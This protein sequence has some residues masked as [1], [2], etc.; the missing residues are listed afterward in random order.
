MTNIYSDIMMLKTIA[1]AATFAHLSTA[2]Q[3][4]QF[5][6]DDNC[7]VNCGI[8]VNLANPG[9]L[10]E[11]GRKSVKIHGTDIMLYSLVVSPRS[12]C[13]C[14]REKKKKTAFAMLHT[15]SSLLTTMLALRKT[16]SK[17]IAYTALSFFLLGILYLL[18]SHICYRDPGSVFFDPNRAYLALYSAVR[19]KQAAA[20]I[21]Q[22]TLST[23]PKCQPDKLPKLCV[24]IASTTRPS[25][26]YL[27]SA[28]GSL[29]VGLD[30]VERQE[31]YLILLIAHTNTSLHPAHNATWID[32]VADSILQYN[33]LPPKEV[34]EIKLLEI[35]EDGIRQKTRIDYILLLEACQRTGASQVLILEDDVLAMDG[36]YHRSIAAAK[37]AYRRTWSMGLSDYL[38]VRLFWSERHQG[39]NKEEWPIYARNIVIFLSI[40]LAVLLAGRA[41]LDGRLDSHQNDNNDEDPQ[42]W[43]NGLR[44]PL[45]KS[46]V[47]LLIGNAFLIVS[48]FVAGRMSIFPYRGPIVQM[49]T[50]GCCTQGLLYPSTRIPT[51]L[52]YLRHQGELERQH[53]AGGIWVDQTIEKFANEEHEL[54]WA[55]VPSVLQHVGAVSATKQSLEKSSY[56]RIFSFSFETMDAEQLRRE[57]QSI[58]DGLH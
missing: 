30:P 7:S 38:Y 54:R 22:A 29:L 17:A 34:E 26:Q 35:S 41:L 32:H 20:Y 16:H 53:E 33:A 46:I 31:I 23:Q 4:A 40:Q 11:N 2:T 19:Q 52:R 55:I 37:E 48:I 39:W 9:C 56:H 12:N 18:S 3:W 21:E 10:N 28:V 15:A 1:L 42:V 58:V 14:Q 49:P 13:P 47:M 25:V 8:S 36:W 51:V 57:H 45:M 27:D 44:L 24:A 5:C 43:H 6:D 50:Y